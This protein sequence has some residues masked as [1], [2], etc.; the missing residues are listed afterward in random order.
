MTARASTRLLRL[1]TFGLVATVVVGF[2]LYQHNTSRLDRITKIVQSPCQRDVDGRACLKLRVKVTRSEPVKIACLIV[3]Q[4]GYPCLSRRHSAQRSN[5]SDDTSPS[6]K[7]A[8]VPTT[9]PSIS[10]PSA[11]T[12]VT[13]SDSGSDNGGTSSTTTTT[14]ITTPPPGPEGPTGPQGPQ[15]PPSGGDNPP[16]PSCVVNVLGVCV[17]NPLDG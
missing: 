8:S 10:P 13:P 7:A 3:E 12:T 5:P 15:G 1:V 4:A 9:P 2:V 6:N 14:I 11:S 17:P 16:P